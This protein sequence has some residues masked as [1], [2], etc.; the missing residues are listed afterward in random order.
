MTET[1]F[2]ERHDVPRLIDPDPAELQERFFDPGLPCL[3]G[4]VH[5][6][7]DLAAWMEGLGRSR[8]SVPCVV[9]RSRNISRISD[10]DRPPVEHAAEHPD[11]HEF[12]VELPLAEAWTRISRPG[13]LPPLLQADECVYVIEGVMPGDCPFPPRVPETPLAAK[14]YADRRAPHVVVNMPGMINRNHAH[15]HEV[16]L[17]QIHH[18]KWARLFSPADTQNLY[19]NA[20][21]RSEV[22]DFDRVDLDRFPRVARAVAWEGVLEPGDV[23]FL[24]SYWWHEIRVAEAAV[25]AGFVVEA[26]EWARRA[27]TLHHAV[28]A[29]LGGLAEGAGDGADRAAGMASI[30]ATATAASLDEIGLAATAE[31]LSF[32]YEQ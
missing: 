20:E 30:V 9:A 21:R 10:A 25:S 1:I 27:F 14:L 8:A 6:Q 24:P 4:S 5:A 17:H 26:G 19:I 11:V 13:E 32:E 28:A 18:R 29:A 23:L 15:V 3:I 12:A 22:P 16:F 7:P 31:A 2:R